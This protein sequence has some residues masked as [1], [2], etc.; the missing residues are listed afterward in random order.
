MKIIILNNTLRDITL[1]QEFAPPTMPQ[2]TDKGGWFSAEGHGCKP[3]CI[4]ALG[5]NNMQNTI[6]VSENARIL[7]E[8][9]PWRAVRRNPAA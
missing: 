5:L 2:G 8:E 4:K 6:R 7:Q 1:F 3:E 9:G